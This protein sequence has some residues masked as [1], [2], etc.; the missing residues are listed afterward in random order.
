MDSPN[1]QKTS[2]NSVFVAIINQGMAS[3]FITNPHST[4]NREHHSKSH[5]QQSDQ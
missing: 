1:N 4:C 5:N 2:A 3:H